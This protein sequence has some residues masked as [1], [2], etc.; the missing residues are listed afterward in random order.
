M[1]GVYKLIEHRRRT[2]F[3]RGRAVIANVAK[4]KETSHRRNLDAQVANLQ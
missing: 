3:T 1:I 4:M 2:V